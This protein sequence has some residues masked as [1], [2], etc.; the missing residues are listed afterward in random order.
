MA[1]KS[2]LQEVYDESFLATM[3]DH[4]PVRYPN[5]GSVSDVLCFNLVMSLRIKI[6]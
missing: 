2:G 3:L 4:L 1:A 5:H 6:C